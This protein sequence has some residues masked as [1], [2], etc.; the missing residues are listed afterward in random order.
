VVDLRKAEHSELR[1]HV[2]PTWH[3]VSL[4]LGNTGAYKMF[5]NHLGQALV[6]SVSIE[7]RVVAGRPDAGSPG[8]QPGQAQSRQVRR[9][10]ARKRQ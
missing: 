10:E 2:W 9:A 5:E 4:T 1:R 3:A 7:Q 6:S 8:A